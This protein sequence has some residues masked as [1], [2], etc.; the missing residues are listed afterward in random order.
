[1]IDGLVEPSILEAI[2]CSESLSLGQ[3]LHLES[4]QVSSNC[5]GVVKDIQVKNLLCAYG[6]IVGEICAKSRAFN[7]VVFGHEN[8]ESNIDAHNLAKAVLAMSPGRYI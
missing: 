4:I 5:L 7:R 2:A 3:D 8:R 6:P 1:M